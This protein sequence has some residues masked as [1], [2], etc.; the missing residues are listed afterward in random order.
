MIYT[1]VKGDVLDEIVYRYYGATMG[2]LAAVYEANRHL[3]DLGDILDADIKITL[4]NVNR[5]EERKEISLWD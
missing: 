3:A 4:P 2:Y 5:K 1:T